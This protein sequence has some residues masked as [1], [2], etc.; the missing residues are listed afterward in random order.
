MLPEQ[1]R[2]WPVI[3]SLNKAATLLGVDRKTLAKNKQLLANCTEVIGC[4]RKI[5][6]DRLLKELKIIE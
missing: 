1:Y 3:M 4:E 2:T 6:R 5:I